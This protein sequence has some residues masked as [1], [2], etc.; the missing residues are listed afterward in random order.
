MAQLF[1]LGVIR[2]MRFIRVILFLFMVFWLLLMVGCPGLYDSHRSF[3]AHSH[4]YDAPSEKTKQELDEAHRLDRRDILVY[5]SVMALILGAA[6]YG[7]IRV[8]RKAESHG[9]QMIRGTKAEFVGREFANRLNICFYP[10]MLTEDGLRAR[11]LFFV[12]MSGVPVCILLGLLVGG[13]FRHL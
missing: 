2:T 5:E 1:S 8:D 9:R 3:V 6:I 10:A 13:V 12:C 11:R 4:Y 7:F